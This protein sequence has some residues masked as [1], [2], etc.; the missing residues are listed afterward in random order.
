MGHSGSV[1]RD[2]MTQMIQNTFDR[3]MED[4]GVELE[5]VSHKV[6]TISEGSAMVTIVWQRREVSWR[7][8]YFFRVMEDGT[9]GWE[10]GVFDGEV[11]SSEAGVG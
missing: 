1:D 8:V 11:S 9:K 3:F 6:D 7:C 5:A 4:G 2:R 10:G